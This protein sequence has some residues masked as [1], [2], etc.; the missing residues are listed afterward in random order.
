MRAA[1]PTPRVA[2]VGGGIAGLATALAILDRVEDGSRAPELTIFEADH[3]PGGN[4]RTM[5]EGPWQLEGGPNGFLDNEPATLRLVNRLGLKDRLLPCSDLTRIRY[6]LSGGRLREI[7]TQP[8]AFLR[9]G[10]LS[11]RAKFRMA[12]ELFVPGRRDL[13]RADTDP[14]TDE[15]VYN[16]GRRRLG[17]EFAEVMLD[18]MVKG[19]FGGD[20]RKLSLAAAFPRMVELEKDHG[21]LF[22]A[23]FS[24]A[25]KRRG[26]GKKIDAAHSGKLT[27][28]SGGMADLVEA[29]HK[30]LVN[31]AD[32]RCASPV[33]TTTRIQGR[34]HVSGPDFHEGPYDVVVNAAPAHAAARHLRESAPDVSA[35]LDSIAFAPMA[36]VALGFDRSA[37]GHDLQGF[38]FLVPSREK[39]DILGC[40]WTS[41]I[42]PDRA[43]D[44]KVLLR[45]MLGGANHPQVMELD[46]DALINLTMDELRP[47]L[48][49]G[50]TPNMAK[51]IKHE[52]AIAQYQP[53]HLARLRKVEEEREETAGMFLT[54]SSYRG[55]AVNSCVKE[56]EKVGE[57]VIRFL[58]ERH[59]PPP[60]EAC[61]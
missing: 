11:P 59:G 40:L 18:P 13:G 57:K 19:I 24:L 29:L 5:R 22:R 41:S 25:R 38:G 27:S 8:G 14:R 7:P 60:E 16:F 28:F 23:M 48:E 61:S 36:V 56:S 33:E 39:R 37:V 17:V 6:L 43:P 52:R 54:G 1:D 10:L 12:G 21:G 31:K 47:L 53:G 50:G 58:S 49:L 3:A 30:E 51:V 34:W 55:I 20:A 9:S 42:F 44:G 46:D 35:E 4:L 2:V 15:T 45:A 32:I 26:T